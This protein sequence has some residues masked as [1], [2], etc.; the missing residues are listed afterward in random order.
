VA[1]GRESG[2]P[3]AA[4]WNSFFDAECVLAKLDCDRNCRDVLEFGCGYGLFTEA[5]ARIVRGT[6]Y[7]L[8]IDPEMVEA[9]RERLREADVTNVSVEER[10][11]VADGSGC[12]DASV[13]YAMLFN[14][15]HIDEPVALLREAFR[16]LTPGGTLGIMHWNYDPAT[17]RGPSMAIRPR[18]EQCRD[19]AIAA[20]F[21]FV[22]FE[23]LTCCEH[24]YGLVCRRPSNFDG[25][26]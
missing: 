4:Y 10:D 5:A 18:P 12:P 25:S 14:I 20:G 1:K 3:E 24:H 9:T 6:V 8:D 22:R 26:E 2:M 23:S 21:E 11:F 17:P 13:D 15:L 19:W 16:A 7:A